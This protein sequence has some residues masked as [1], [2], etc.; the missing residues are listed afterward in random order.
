M[1]AAL[2]SLVVSMVAALMLSTSPAGAEPV[3]VVSPSTGLDPAAAF[4]VVSGSGYLP[5]TQLFVMQCRGNSTDDH[6]CN[7]VGLRKVTT[8]ASGSFTADA[9]RLVSR[10]GA[11]DCTVEQ[12]AVMTSAVSGHSDDRSQDR[13]T[14]IYFATAPAPTVPPQTEPTAPAPTVAPPDATVPGPSTSA[15]PTTTATAAPPSSTTTTAVPGEASDS[16]SGSQDD[17]GDR[18]PQPGDPELASTTGEPEPDGDGSSRGLVIA[19]SAGA[20][21]VGAAGLVAVRRRRSDAD[22]D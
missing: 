11:T 18:A 6:S 9:M 8:D 7:S 3:L 14:P 17:S 10:F 2:G 5:N 16:T 15:A 22:P 19:L 1:R 20:A 4:V 21:A 12:C 13:S